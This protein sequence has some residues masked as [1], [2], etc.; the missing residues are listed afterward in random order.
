MFSDVHSAVG[1]SLILYEFVHAY[2]MDLFCTTMLA[3]VAKNL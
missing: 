1:S 2:A 3:P